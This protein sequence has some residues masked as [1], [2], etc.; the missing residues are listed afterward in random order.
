[1]RIAITPGEPAG[2]G[3][4]LI[5]TLAQQPHA[6]CLVAIADPDM[7]AQRAQQ[8]G[9]PL[10]L[11]DYEPDSHSGPARAGELMVAPYALHADC[12]AGQLDPNNA[13]YLMDTLMRATD[14]CLDGEF[15]AM[16]TA[17]VHKGI[18]NDAGI[19]FS[20]HTEFLA[21]RCKVDMPVML[22]C[23]DKL[24]VALVTTHLP[25]SQVSAAI[26]EERL[27][28]V[29]RVVYQDMQRLFGLTDPHIT[30]LGVNPHAGEN[31]HMGREEIEVIEP[32]LESLRGEG[33]NLL[34]PLPA[35]SAFSGDLLTNTDVYLA[36]FHDQGLPVLKYAGFGE[37]VNITLG[38]PII[39][40]S[41]DHGTALDLAGTGKANCGSLETALQLAI[42]M[43]ELRRKTA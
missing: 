5:V 30:V 19:A 43:A 10:Q 7:L 29:I 22:L 28:A 38:L 20:G 8:L 33:L 13:S 36:M 14:G 17:P 9:L 32:T 34:G 15:D 2:I 12:V 27:T 23:T 35:D 31:G 41:V 25:L 39:R 6:A 4:D 16:L 37:A 1:M 24:R 3:P 21:E 18:I 26:T 11:R 40:T 42:N